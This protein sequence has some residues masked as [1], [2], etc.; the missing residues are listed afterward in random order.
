MFVTVFGTADTQTVS[1]KDTTSVTYGNGFDKCGARQYT[2]EHTDQTT[3]V[4]S[5]I[6]ITGDVITLFT[7]NTAYEGTTWPLQVTISFTGAYSGRPSIVETFTAIINDCVVTS[8]TA[9]ALPVPNPQVYEV[10]DP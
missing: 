2:L 9:P 6:S 7:E 5:F 3:D 10:L 8:T 4:S 1:Y